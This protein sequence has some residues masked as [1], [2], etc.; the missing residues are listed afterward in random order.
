[1]P[2]TPINTNFEH[3]SYAYT[4]KNSLFI[5]VDAFH[6]RSDDYFDRAL[7]SGGEGAVSCTVTGDHLLWFE[8]LLIEANKDKSIKHIFVQAHIP[9][10][11]PVRK[12]NCSGQFMDQGTESAF[13]K[14]MVKHNVD[15]YF[16]GEV[17]ATTASKDPDSNLIQVVSRANRFNNFLN[18]NVEDNGF[19]I[20]AYNEVGTE[21]RWNANYTQYGLLTVDKS[22]SSNTVITSSGILKII[23][24]ALPLIRMR[25]EKYHVFPLHDR[26]IVGMKYNEYKQMLGGYTKAIRGV[27]STEGM[28]N[29]GVF[30]RK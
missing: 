3:T 16:A 15:V 28:M 17:H 24:P 2:T 21:W 22:D 12:I 27:N 26:I 8:R 1:M 14:L 25:L 20:K 6:K 30:G 11:Q 29:V 4:H 13:W 18:V 5:T 9:I 10:L 19:S 7:N 23:D